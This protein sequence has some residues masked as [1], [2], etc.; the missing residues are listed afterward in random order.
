LWRNGVLNLIFGFIK[1]S[2]RE[3]VKQ[4]MDDLSFY[5]RI[6]VR[7]KLLLLIIFLFW[8][9]LYYLS[10]AL[11]G[12][13]WPGLGFVNGVY[14]CAAYMIAWFVGY[15]S[16]FTPSGL[17]VREAV[18]VALS[19]G[20]PPE[21]IAAIILYGRFALTF[22]DIVLGMIHLPFKIMSSELVNHE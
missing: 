19:I 4:T 1:K 14:L 12:L 10:W 21:A 18:F 11:F 22:A 9:A 13:S 15:L 17:G 20:Y 5:F 7:D 16:F 6:S 8:W 2:K 3:F